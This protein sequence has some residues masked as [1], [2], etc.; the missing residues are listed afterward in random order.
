ML[1]IHSLTLYIRLMVNTS[2]KKIIH[3]ILCHARRDQSSSQLK[4]ELHP[5]RI[6]TSGWMACGWFE[7]IGA[8]WWFADCNNNESV[9]LSCKII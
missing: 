1:F 8:S 3:L 2:G 7:A 5:K 4:F 9:S 6:C